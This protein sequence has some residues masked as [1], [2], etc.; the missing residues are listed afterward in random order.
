LF[1]VAVPT[2]VP[3]LQSVGAED[4]GPNTLNVIVP[5]GLTPP[6]N[7]ELIEPAPIATFVVPLPGANTEVLVVAGFATVVEIIPAP[8]P[9]FDAA[10]LVSPP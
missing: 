6:D 10:L 2:V 1:T 8:Q 5:I 3:P 7:I 4:C 9:L